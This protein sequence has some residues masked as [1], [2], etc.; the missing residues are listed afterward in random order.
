MAF[1]ALP[2]AQA[3]DEIDLSHYRIG[4]LGD[5]A[6]VE[7]SGL[8]CAGPGEFWTHNDAGND[9]ALF[10]LGADGE[11]VRALKV[12][13]V[14]NRDWEDLALYH[15]GNDV[16]LVVA[17]IGDNAGVRPEVQLYVLSISDDGEVPVFQVDERYRLRYPGGARDS[18]SLA[19]DGWT[20]TAWLLSK[21]TIPAELY[22]V[23]LDKP[24]DDV[25]TA[26]FAGTLTTLPQPTAS[27]IALAPERMDWFWQPTAMDFSPDG[28]RAAVLTY[29]AVYLYSRDDGESW[30]EALSMRP[31]SFEIG[32]GWAAEALCL[33]EDAVYWTTEGESAPIFRIPLNDPSW[34]S[35]EPPDP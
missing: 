25:V 23:P 4:T 2:A 11:T 26:T 12:H 32:T 15:Q 14:E 29:E 19:I 8:A 22:T 35:P 24:S 7:S 18:E 3:A 31:V 27:E 34:A 17:D 16:R 5:P 21:R 13:G 9:A 10:Q 33:S 20:N 6:I 30:I 1:T 28:R